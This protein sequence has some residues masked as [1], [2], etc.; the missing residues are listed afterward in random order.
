MQVLQNQHGH[1]QQLLAAI[2]VM[3]TF[4]DQGASTSAG[5]EREAPSNLS[6]MAGFTG[7][8]PQTEATFYQR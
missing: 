2:P 1:L 3:L 6:T 5:S 4:L 8:N 7:D